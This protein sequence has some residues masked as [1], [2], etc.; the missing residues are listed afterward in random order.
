MEHSFVVFLIEQIRKGAMSTSAAAT[1]AG[2][3][4]RMVQRWLQKYSSDSEFRR[5]IDSSLIKTG[6][7]T[8]ENNKDLHRLCKQNAVRQWVKRELQQQKLSKTEIVKRIDELRAE[9]VTVLE[10]C[11][12]FQI[13]FYG[14]S[15]LHRDDQGDTYTGPAYRNEAEKLGI[16]LS[17]SRKGNCYDNAS[18]GNFYGHL[19][20][21]TI[22]QMP[23]HQRYGSIREELM[24]VINDYIQWYNEERILE[25]LGYLSPPPSSATTFFQGKFTLASETP[26]NFFKK[27]TLETVVN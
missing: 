19:K 23:F 22:Y 18:M 16:T 14:G 1:T 26:Q 4:I 24:A 21:E 11:D 12:L 6:M 9:G 8:M 3:C 15:L 17:D 20:S 7:R 5:T 27:M 13:H 10:A 25:G 2:V